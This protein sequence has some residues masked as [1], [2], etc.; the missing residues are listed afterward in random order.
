MQVEVVFLTLCSPAIMSGVWRVK[1]VMFFS[2]R[3]MRTRC[4][5]V[6]ERDPI[7][8]SPMIDIVVKRF[9]GDKSR[10]SIEPELQN[11]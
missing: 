6:D 9:E 4:V 11:I 3:T 7:N 2:A 10:A 8:K 1:S 5:H